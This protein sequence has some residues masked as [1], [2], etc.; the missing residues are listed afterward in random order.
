MIEHVRCPKCEKHISYDAATEVVKCGNCGWK[1][2]QPEIIKVITLHEPWASL[3]INS[4]KKLE[5][6]RHEQLKYLAGQRIGIHAGRKYDGNAW[7]Q[8]KLW[9]RDE[10]AV[11][12][13]MPENARFLTMGAILGT[14]TVV[15]AD[16]IKQHRIH[17]HAALVNCH[18]DRRFG[19][20]LADVKKFAEPIPWTGRQGAWNWECPVD[21]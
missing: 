15:S 1:Q 4:F 11:Q 16:W 18:D 8:V 20:F 19:L 13:A 7:R 6:R 3:I 12:M 2:Q 10:A 14:A 17:T 21:A 9:A 5:T